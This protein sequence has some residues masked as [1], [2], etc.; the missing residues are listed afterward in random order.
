MDEVQSSAGSGRA[1]PPEA[2]SHEAVAKPSLLRLAVGSAATLG[3]F[4]YETHE[5]RE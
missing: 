4:L 5:A 1:S 2:L 3:V